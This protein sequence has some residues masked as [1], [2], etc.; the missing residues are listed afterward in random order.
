MSSKTSNQ[1][2][3]ASF[4]A[5]LPCVQET[6]AGPPLGAA[7]TATARAVRAMMTLETIFDEVLMGGEG[8]TGVSGGCPGSDFAEVRLLGDSEGE[9]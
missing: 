8:A 9:C 6:W 1:T 3:H 2:Q 5:L 7:E 4:E